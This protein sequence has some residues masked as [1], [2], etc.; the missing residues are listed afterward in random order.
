MARLLEN[1]N[2]DWVE[3]K[4]ILKSDVSIGIAPVESRRK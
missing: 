3:G 1:V 4:V 2:F